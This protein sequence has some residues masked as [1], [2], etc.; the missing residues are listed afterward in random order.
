MNFAS[1]MRKHH[2]PSGAVGFDAVPS[3]DG[4]IRQRPAFEFWKIEKRFESRDGN[5]TVALHDINL[6]VAAGELLTI[7]GSSGC[8]KS[9][10]L[11]ILAGI[12]TPTSGG[13]LI[14]D[15]ESDGP[16]REVG[17][18]FQAPVLMPWRTVLENSLLIAQ[19]QKAERRAA[20]ARAKDYL[21]LVGLKDFAEKYPKEL[22]GGMQQRVGIVRALVN[23]PALLLMDEPFGALDAMTREQMNLELLRL[24]RR[25]GTTVMLVTH[26]IPEAVFL[27]TRVVV[28]TPR[29]GRI[30]EVIEID[31]PSDRTLELINTPEFGAY[32][33]RIRK[34]LNASGGL[35]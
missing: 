20:M 3:P 15:R 2:A 28:M 6:K 34:I 17:V 16:N 29:P 24:K 8:G 30:E 25:S 13:V 27:G 18:V 21:E 1:I 5:P 9:T 32:V 22:S 19:V 31:L 11:R 4:A 23:D 35:D 26:S 33:K 10:L 12:E 14:G 7:V